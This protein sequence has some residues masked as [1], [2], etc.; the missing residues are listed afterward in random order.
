M[1]SVR[2]MISR[3]K[4]PRRHMRRYD[5]DWTSDFAA[6][7]KSGLKTASSSIASGAKA[8]TIEAINY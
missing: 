4:S 8:A 2:K 7:A 3:R 1:R 6:R 5:G